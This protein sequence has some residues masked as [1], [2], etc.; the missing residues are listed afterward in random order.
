MAGAQPIGSQSILAWLEIHCVS[1]P[2][3]RARYYGAITMLDSEYL[4][5]AKEK[6]ATDE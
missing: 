6:G 1:D 4:K 3:E 2:E 5:L